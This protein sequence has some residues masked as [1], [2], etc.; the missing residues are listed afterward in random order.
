M[1]DSHLSATTGPH[2]SWFP[3]ACVPSGAL[4]SRP[5]LSGTL[6]IDEETEACDLDSEQMTGPEEVCTLSLV[7]VC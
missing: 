3:E 6:V 2:Y 1:N 4:G 5:G 7:N